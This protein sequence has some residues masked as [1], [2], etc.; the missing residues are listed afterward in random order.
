MK[1]VIVEG[2]DG[3]GKSTLIER[4]RRE[5]KRH[6]LVIHRANPPRTRADLAGAADLL[7]AASYSEVDVICDRHPFISE[8]IYGLTLRGASLLEGLF[9]P[10]AV[11]ATLCDTVGRII[12]CRPPIES[13]VECAK[14]RE[15]LAG[16]HEKILT[17]IEAYDEMFSRIRLENLV[18]TL[19]YDWTDELAH[20]GPS[21]PIEQL[22]F[23]ALR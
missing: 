18:P 9:S 3:S 12:Y 13:I 7:T 19:Y 14:N 6:F 10:G 1:L 8:P 2:P 23:G 15:Q 11:R 21:Y 5:S 17:L 20:F 22:F 16:V 4:L